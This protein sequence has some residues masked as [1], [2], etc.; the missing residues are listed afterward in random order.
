MHYFKW[1][2][3]RPSY[4]S[5]S[6]SR[7]FWYLLWYQ[8]LFQFF[9]TTN[10]RCI[11]G[12]L[13]Y[14]Y[15]VTL[16]WRVWA[17]E[18]ATPFLDGYE[19]WSQYWEEA[20]KIVGEC[21]KRRLLRGWLVNLEGGVVKSLVYPMKSL[22]VK[23]C[24]S[25]IMRPVSLFSLKVM[26]FIRLSLSP[27][28]KYCCR[29]IASPV[30]FTLCNLQ[31]AN[32]SMLSMNSKTVDWNFHASETRFWEEQYRRLLRCAGIV[33]GSM[34]SSSR[35][36]NTFFSTHWNS[37]LFNNLFV[38]PQLFFKRTTWGWGNPVIN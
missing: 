30:D 4:F 19:P 20:W 24:E 35:L 38:Q 22:K 23:Y 18:N 9:S 36:K 8:F 10:D 13:I 33:V 31:S 15:F 17:N 12:M 25:H 7:Y 16:L 28:I 27:L 37:R 26:H 5:L 29:Q 21:P 3:C 1:K 14:C 34:L 32:K 2:V 11:Q 6:T